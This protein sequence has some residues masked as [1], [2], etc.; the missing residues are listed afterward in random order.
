[1]F[2]IDWFEIKLYNLIHVCFGDDFYGCRV[3]NKNRSKY[4]C[5]TI[6]T[7]SLIARPRNINAW[8]ALA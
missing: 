2:F 8:L 1:M 6:P 4:L 3:T 5:F 7:R